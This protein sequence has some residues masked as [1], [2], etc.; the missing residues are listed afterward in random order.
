MWQD[1][2]NNADH[3]PYENFGSKRKESSCTMP[4]KSSAKRTKSNLEQDE[5]VQYALQV[6][7]SNFRSLY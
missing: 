5:Q 6:L 7:S 2:K 4:P 3:F 1:N